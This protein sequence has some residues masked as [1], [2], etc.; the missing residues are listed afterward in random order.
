VWTCIG[1]LV[2]ALANF[3][4][5]AA[6]AFERVVIADPFLELHTGP[7]R[8]YPVTYIAERGESVEILKRHT[9]WFKLRTARGKEGWAAREQME[10]TLTAA[11]VQTTFRDV[12]IEDYLRRRLEFGFSVGR[13]ESDPIL[14]AHVGYRLQEHFL[15]ELNVSQVPGQFS[16]TSLIYG[17]LVSQMYPD[18]TWSPY[19]ALGVGHFNNKP[20]A[21]L[22]SAIETDADLANAGVGVRYYLTRQFVLRV[23]WKQHVALIDHN[24]NETF[25]EWS[26]GIFSFF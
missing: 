7:G 22:V 4:A 17:S 25:R 12:L 9:D 16:S 5:W 6:E 18:Q 15:V 19:L 2:L 3:S 14:T 20:K 23:E 10:R 1:L 11:G 21:T 8:G 26:L 24:R 13:F